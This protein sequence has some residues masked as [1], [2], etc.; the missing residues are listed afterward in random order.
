[1]YKTKIKAWNL[2][3]YLKEYEAQQIIDGKIPASETAP[4]PAV[5]KEPEEA[6]KRAARSLKRKR[7]RERAQNQPSPTALE[8]SVSKPFPSQT[9]DAMLPCTPPRDVVAAPQGFRVNG[10]AEQFLFNLR[11][12]THD[13]FVFGHWDTKLS[14]QHHS[15]RQASRLLSSNLTA[16]TNLYEKGKQQLAWIY[17]NRAVA[18][19]H[20]PDLFKT[21]YHETPI[22]LL[23]EVGR[24]AHSGHGQLAAIL[25][26]SIKNWA[27]TFLKE[28]DSRHA[29]FS[30][31]GEL[32]VAQLRDLYV[33]VAHCLY[34]GLD[35]RIDK[36]NPLRYE[37]RL[38]RAL[39]MLWYDPDSDLT[40]WLPP[41]EEVD[42]A[43]G[44]NNPYSV[45]FLLLQAYRLV[46]QESYPEAD[47]VCSQVRTRLA[48]M[49]EGS[50][51][52][53][54]VGL[55]YRRLGRQQHSKGLYTDARRSFNTALK[56]VGSGN[57]LSASILIEICQSQ[58]SMANAFDDQEDAV[59]WSH[60]LRQ[61][62]QQTEYQ[63]EVDMSQHPRLFAPPAKR[64]PSARKDAFGQ[65]LVDQ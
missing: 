34:N 52:S 40:E 64:S 35:S 5:A 38:N 41:I 37:V 48:A 9:S 49:K 15:G 60:M 36:H 62:E 56:H 24:V 16:G 46:A 58:E 20:S 39:D 12:W 26:Q 57:R 33:R 29:L 6:V 19:F 14:A 10:V 2:R 45:Y 25:L 8:S 63:D 18:N 30:V 28:D 54:R 44:P 17:W 59:L 53:W 27:H 4:V 51:D 50:I 47:Q 61:L 23:F 22:R 3:K 21:W 7:A 55:A 32:D 31:F 65:A 11:A 43:C 1:M 42:Q 13:A